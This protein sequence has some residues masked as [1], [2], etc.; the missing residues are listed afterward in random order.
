MTS[1]D[2]PTRTLVHRQSTPFRVTI[3]VTWSDMCLAGFLINIGI[4]IRLRQAKDLIC[5]KHI[6]PKDLI[7]RGCRC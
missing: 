4:L 5:A 6:I 3:D 2:V 7:L 1:A